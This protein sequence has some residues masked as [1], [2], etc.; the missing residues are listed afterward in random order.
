MTQGK[1]MNCQVKF[2]WIGRPLLRKAYCP[3][4]N[5]K[6]L[7]TSRAMRKFPTVTG[8]PSDYVTPRLFKSEWSSAVKP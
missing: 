6:L 8:R 2:E 4:C 5:C 3:R 1:C 7:Q